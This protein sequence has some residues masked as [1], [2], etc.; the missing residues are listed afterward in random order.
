M[1]R[2][3]RPV[4]PEPEQPEQGRLRMYEAKEC[5][6]GEWDVLVPAPND[7]PEWFEPYLGQRYWTEAEAKIIAFA[8]SVIANGHDLTE[9][10]SRPGRGVYE[11]IYDG[12]TEGVVRVP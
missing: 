10:W 6:P 1:T 9:R 5:E 4:S 12:P 3:P 7:K 8:L 2:D 11:L